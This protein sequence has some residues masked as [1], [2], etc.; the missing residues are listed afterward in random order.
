M[1]FKT[2]KRA[3]VNSDTLCSQTRR[4]TIV[5]IRLTTLIH[6]FHAMPIKMLTGLSMEL[7]KVIPNFAWKSEGQRPQ[8][9]PRTNPGGGGQ[10]TRSHCFIQK[11]SN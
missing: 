4:L 1:Y 11:S 10:P 9:T 2:L 5:K 6:R 7:D 8:D 3:S